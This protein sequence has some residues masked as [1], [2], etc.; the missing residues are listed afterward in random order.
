VDADLHRGLL[1]GF[2]SIVVWQDAAA[3][4]IHADLP[5]CFFA[6]RGAIVRLAS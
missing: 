3:I 4:G 1:Q 6:A 2:G 5:A